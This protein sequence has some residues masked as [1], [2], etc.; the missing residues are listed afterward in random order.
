[1]N[2]IWIILRG[3][4]REEYV[5]H[6]DLSA[7]PSYGP[8]TYKGQDYQVFEVG[9]ERVG[10]D[11]RTFVKVYRQGGVP[12]CERCRGIVAAFRFGDPLPIREQ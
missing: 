1:M 4:C 7:F 9:H 2:G 10:D 12:L 5:A 11:I 6:T 3:C 8:F